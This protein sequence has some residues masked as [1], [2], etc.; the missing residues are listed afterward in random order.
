[1]DALPPDERDVV[2]LHYLL[3]A[4]IA[5]IA[6]RLGRP[7]GTVGYWLFCARRALKGKL[8]HL[9]AG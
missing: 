6:A 1:M 2:L 4:P 3:G 9:T 8:G 7:E 5:E